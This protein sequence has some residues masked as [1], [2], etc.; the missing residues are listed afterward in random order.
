MTAGPQTRRHLFLLQPPKHRTVE[1]DRD[2]FDYCLF[3]TIAELV[4]D[5]DVYR[6]AVEGSGDDGIAYPVAD[7]RSRGYA[8]GLVYF[9][10]SAEEARERQRQSG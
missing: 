1:T 9:E 7:I 8:M 10:L 5:A 6:I 4:L 3:E 2:G